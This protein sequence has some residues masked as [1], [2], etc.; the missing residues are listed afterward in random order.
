M[1]LLEDLSMSLISFTF[2][3]IKNRMNYLK[4]NIS[5]C[6]FNKYNR[7]LF[8]FF[9]IFFFMIYNNGKHN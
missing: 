3:M 7:L 9:F 5:K 6:F 4:E 8:F 2:V 1:D